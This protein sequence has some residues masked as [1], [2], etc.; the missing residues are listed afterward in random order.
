MG[1]VIPF[2][3]Y[4]ESQGRTIIRRGQRNVRCTA[5]KRVGPTSVSSVR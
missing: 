3:S 1:K 2:R 4:A 5:R